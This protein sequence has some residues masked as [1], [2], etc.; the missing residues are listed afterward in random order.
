MERLFGA[1]HRRVERREHLGEAAQV[2]IVSRTY[3]T[4][5]ADLWEAITTPARIA[6]WFAP[7]HG[8]LTLGGRYQVEGNASGTITRCE[9]PEALALTWEFGGGVSWVNVA[10]ERDGARAKLTLEHIAHEAGIGADHLKQ[11]GPG[12]T[13][14]GWDLSLHGLAQHLSSPEVAVDPAQVAAWSTSPE[15]LTFM[16]ESGAA[17]AEADAASGEDPDEARAKAARTIAFYTGS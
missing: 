15:G 3:D 10:L 11:Y 9:P 13:G 2:M 4:T 14:I 7:V 1:A 6:R 5:V 12:A 16:R 8:E 17:W